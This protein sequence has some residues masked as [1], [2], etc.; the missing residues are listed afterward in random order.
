MLIRG[1]EGK[2]NKNLSKP[3]L[4]LEVADKKSQPSLSVEDQLV[5]SQRYSDFSSDVF[6]TVEVQVT[7]MNRGAIKISK[8]T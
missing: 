5:Y 8:N 1:N 6:H 2:K 3:F 4:K 7:G